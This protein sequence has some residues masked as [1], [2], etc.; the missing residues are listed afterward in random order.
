MSVRKNLDELI[1]W[2][3]AHRPNAGHEIPVNATANTVRRFA[4]K[5]RRGGPY[6]YRDRIIVPVRPASAEEATPARTARHETR[7]T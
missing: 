6:T 4:R 2:Y 5:L 3:E 1:R 7:S